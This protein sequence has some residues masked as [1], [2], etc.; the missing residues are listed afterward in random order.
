[1]IKAVS[2]KSNRQDKYPVVSYYDLGVATG[3]MAAKILTGEANVEEMPIEYA[4][5]FTKK[6]N[7]TICADLGVAVPEGYVA[8][9][10]AE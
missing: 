9:E 7:E 3:K 2:N 4:P 10:T 8:I 5:Q 1:M 6:F